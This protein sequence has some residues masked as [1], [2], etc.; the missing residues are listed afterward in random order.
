[1]SDHIT[2]NKSILNSTID[3][4]DVVDSRSPMSYTVYLKLTNSEN[5]TTTKTKYEEYVSEW[6]SHYNKKPTSAKD[7]ITEKYKEFLKD[8]TINYTTE[9]E[10]K[11][12]ST[13]NF[14]D[15]LDLEIAIPLFTKKIYE[16]S[17][18][19]ENKRE[20]VKNEI[21]NKKLQGSHLGIE[22]RLKKEIITILENLEGYKIELDID[23]I[24]DNIDVE[25]EELFNIP[26]DDE[27][28]DD[29]VKT[30][31]PEE[32][33]F[34]KYY[35]KS[36]TYINGDTSD[37]LRNYSSGYA[38]SDFLSKNHHTKF[39]G[40][41][42]NIEP[43]KNKYFDSIENFGY[44]K[45]VKSDINGN[46]FGLLIKDGDI[47]SNTNNNINSIIN[48]ST[49]Y[50]QILDGYR[51]NDVLFQENLN[52]NYN[53]VDN[54]TY[55]GVER[56][57]LSGGN[58]GTFFP[59]TY[60]LKID[61]GGFNDI[62]F[63]QPTEDLLKSDTFIIDGFTFTDINNL[64]YTET[65]SSDLSSFETEPSE[66]FY[67]DTLIEGGVVGGDLSQ[68]ALVDPSYPSLTASFYPYPETLDIRVVDGGMFTQIIDFDSQ[69]VTSETILLSSETPS[70]LYSS[71][72]NTDYNQTIY[73][74]N[75]KSKKISPILEEM[76]FLN[77]KYDNSTINELTSAV[78][79][80]EMADDLIFIETPTKFI[81]E[82]IKY[83][84]GKFESP[85][86][87]IRLFTHN[88]GPFDKISNRYKIDNY[89]YFSK[90][91]Y[92]SKTNFEIK[93]YFEIYQTDIKTNK[94]ILLYPYNDIE[95][96]TIDEGEDLLTDCSNPT[97][98]HDQRR[99][100]FTISTVFKNQN[101]YPTI[102]II[103]F[104]LKPSPTF[105]T[106]RII[107]LS[108]DKKT[109]IL[110]EFTFTP[111]LSSSTPSTSEDAIVL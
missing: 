15:P 27:I 86:N 47:L 34:F 43:N 51:F 94:T 106:H 95:Y 102:S 31:N 55:L 68:R 16:I 37:L 3:D 100:I 74:K 18:Y 103:D 58:F 76:T 107:S 53:T 77:S 23:T 11:F 108:K 21:T 67:Y 17:K 99:N 33:G 54:S 36:P 69:E 60:D 8:L 57:G 44:F 110:S 48:D 84:N 2:I 39:Y 93:F 20:D 41:T 82:K 10:K 22:K 80:F 62:L 59:N 104:Y 85:S 96:F 5:N 90:I 65:V 1:M 70:I 105:T 30:I 9:E 52:F 101:F 29:Y 7:F 73:I 75:Q 50:Y 6:Y 49:T 83:N 19:Y 88:S 38:S 56:S 28:V 64:F 111:I 63:P 79:K 72:P 25:I 91:K 32:Y 24:K 81:I 13:L 78:N 26:T 97:L 40:Y 12:L 98:S 109:N 14:N 46:L 66:S 45:D 89:V 42:S 35:K 61:L 4:E 87:I 92:V 71:T